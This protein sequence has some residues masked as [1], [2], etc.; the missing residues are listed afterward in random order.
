M[1]AEVQ[2]K[3]FNS[4]ERRP[5]MLK[6]FLNENSNSC[7]SNGFKSLPRKP[8]NTLHNYNNNNN[9]SLSLIIER[10]NSSSN[11][12]HYSPFQTLINTITSISFFTAV[13][14]SPSINF[15][16]RSLSRKLS[17]SRRNRRNQSFCNASTTVKIKDIIRWKSFRDL[18]EDHHPQQQQQ[19]QP[20]LSSPP[21]DFHRY[22]SVG[23]PITTTTTTTT[24]TTCRSS[25]SSWCESDFTSGY[26]SSWEAQNDN[27]EGGKKFSFSPL[28]VGKGSVEPAIGTAE[29]T[30]EVR[31]KEVLTCQE[32][33]QQSPVS[34]LEVGDGE[35][36]SFDQSLANIQ[37][38]KQK[39]MQTVQRF[40]SLAKFDLEDLDQSPSLDEN[41]SYDDDDDD[42]H[43][44]E[45]EE[46]NWIK[47]RARELLQCVKARDSM[48]SCEEDYYLD[49]L[50]LDFFME[51]LSG[52]RN[53]LENDD[54]FECEILRKA[55]DWLNGLFSY[56]IELVNKDSYIKDLDRRGTWSTFEEEKEDLALEIETAILQNLVADLLNMDG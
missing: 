3:R 4:M 14:K 38:R 33:E 13:K 35:F 43:L 5:R 32:D 34:V 16:P 44:E 15:L 10:E 27:V 51:E 42:H 7:S 2:L 24:T 9:H 6:D 47:E 48:H 12:Y 21:L 8:N 23:S 53:Q 40:E 31:D 17:R 39:F 41:S 49:T 37:R 54:K 29:Y 22:A 18:V 20:H 46:Q 25:D 52:R 26:L 30:A 45:F 36:S 11:S 19:Q 55:E 28:V 1:S 56:D 50:L